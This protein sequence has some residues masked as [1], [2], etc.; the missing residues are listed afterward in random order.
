M[1]GHQ[2]LEATMIYIHVM[3]K[4]GRG[5]ANPLDT[6]LR[7]VDAAEANMLRYG[8]RTA[9]NLPATRNPQNYQ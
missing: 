9:G 4:G 7:R 1:I 2:S 8:G 3:N 6:G 5:V